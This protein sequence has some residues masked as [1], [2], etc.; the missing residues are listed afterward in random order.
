M[1]TVIRLIAAA[2][3]LLLVIP[4]A[5]CIYDG[6]PDSSGPEPE[7]H[8]GVYVCETGR[9]VFPGDGKTVRIEINDELASRLGLPAGDYE[10]T[11]VFLYNS[12]IWRYDQCDE[13][14]IFVNGATYRFNNDFT[15]TSFERI[16]ISKADD[17]GNYFVF[18][19]AGDG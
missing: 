10:A 8:R 2:A 9:L 16:V 7:D 17:P 5:A 14:R 12:G 18:E 1:K 4:L 13:L 15:S 19:R 6:P 11:Y 3:A